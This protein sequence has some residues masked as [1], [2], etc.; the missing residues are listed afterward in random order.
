MKSTGVP[1]HLATASGLTKVEDALKSSTQT[2]LTE[3][4]IKVKSDVFN[5]LVINGAVPITPQD[6][7]IQF[8]RMFAKVQSQFRVDPKQTE[9]KKAVN[10]DPIMFTWGGRFH[11]IPQ[12]FTM[13]KVDC[14]SLWRL[15]HYGRESDKITSFSTFHK[16]DFTQ[17]KEAAKYFKGQ[18]VMNTLKKLGMELNIW[19][20]EKLP[21]ECPKSEMDSVFDRTF[22][23][24]IKRTYKKEKSHR[25]GELSYATISN[26]INKYE[27]LSSASVMGAAVTIA[28]MSDVPQ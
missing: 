7:Q 12:N 19:P 26:Q 16:Y 21:K 2:L 8:D 22:A 27:K 1:P 3:I 14:K 4:P 23:E 6:L 5:N 24:L 13:P 11:P 20:T 9:E 10:S 18:K 17:A 28:T 25:V 15:W